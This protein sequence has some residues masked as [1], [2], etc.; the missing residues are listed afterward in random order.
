M[1]I[2]SLDSEEVSRAERMGEITPV[3]ANR[4]REAMARYRGAPDKPQVR[5]AVQREDG[6]FI[7]EVIQSQDETSWMAQLYGGVEVPDVFTDVVQAMRFLR[8]LSTASVHKASA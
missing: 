8:E 5:V 2:L 7:G 3:Q 4:A 1:L 6:R